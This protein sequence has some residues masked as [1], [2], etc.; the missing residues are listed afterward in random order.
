MIEKEKKMFPI[1]YWNMISSK[2]LFNVLV[3]FEKKKQQQ[4]KSH[5]HRTTVCKIEARDEA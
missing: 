5:H 3:Q 1:G 2:H 4:K